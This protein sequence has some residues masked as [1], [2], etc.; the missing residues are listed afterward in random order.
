MNSRHQTG[1]FLSILVISSAL[2]LRIEITPDIVPNANA[3]PSRVQ[4][5]D[6]ILD[7]IFSLR[8]F[9]CSGV[10]IPKSAFSYMEI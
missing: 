8:T 1:A 6:I 7:E 5:A 9:V 10:Q 3:L 4:A 2:W